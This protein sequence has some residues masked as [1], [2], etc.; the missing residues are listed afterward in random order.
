MWPASIRIMDINFMGKK[1]KSPENKANTS[2]NFAL[3][4][5]QIN[6]ASNNLQ[7]SYSELSNQN[8][9]LTDSL[10]RFLNQ[11]HINYR[12]F[13]TLLQNADTESTIVSKMSSLLSCYD[14][15]EQIQKEFRQCE[16]DFRKEFEKLKNKHLENGT[17][18]RKAYESKKGVRYS[19]LGQD[20]KNAL[21]VHQKMKKE[22]DERF[23]YVKDELKSMIE[24]SDMRKWFQVYD[25]QQ[26]TSTSRDV[27]SS[28]N[29]PADISEAGS[30]SNNPPDIS[31]MS[32]KDESEYFQ[33]EVKLLRNNLRH[34][35]GKI[36]KKID[37]LSE[38]DQLEKKELQSK[39]DWYHS[40]TDAELMQHK[41]EI[42]E[43][44][45]SI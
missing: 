10:N 31:K 26:S 9:K 24:I 33:K 36:N 21:T 32:I 3:A 17:N 2:D 27:G 7:I 28:S 18:L 25:K 34:K 5:D 22:H 41:Q 1:K 11:I 15:F 14:K 45:G 20:I 19:D 43:L 42:E 38:K 16:T 13:Q 6:K 40:K 44:L 8:D 37:N 30:S 4:V 29:V 39:L 23:Q 35:M 12:L